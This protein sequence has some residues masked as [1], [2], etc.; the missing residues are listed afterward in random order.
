MWTVSVSSDASS[1]VMEPIG[2]QHPRIFVRLGFIGLQCRVLS[3]EHANPKIAGYFYKAVVQSIL[4]YACETWVLSQCICTAFAGFH[5][6][7]ARRLTNR[8]IRLDPRTQQC[9]EL[10]GYARN[11]DKAGDSLQACAA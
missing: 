2:R 5:H 4:L 8:R 10:V 11:F 3:P 7:V 9:Q 1:F 6:Q